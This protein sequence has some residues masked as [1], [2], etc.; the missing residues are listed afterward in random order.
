VVIHDLGIVSPFVMP[1]KTDSP[2]VIDTDAVLTFAIALQC[3]ELVAGG[4]PQA[5]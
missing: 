1:G 5:C 4:D 2:L 3:L